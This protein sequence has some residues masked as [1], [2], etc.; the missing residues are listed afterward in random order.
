M[1][2]V[3]GTKLWINLNL[4]KHTDWEKQ[5]VETASASLQTPQ[6]TVALQRMPD[7]VRDNHDAST[8]WE[9]TEERVINKR[10]KLMQ[11]SDVGTLRLNPPPPTSMLLDMLQDELKATTSTAIKSSKLRGIIKCTHLFSDTVLRARKRAKVD[12]SQSERQ[13]LVNDR[14]EAQVEE[15][16][17][18]TVIACTTAT[19]NR[20]NGG[21]N[22]WSKMF[23]ITKKTL[24]LADEIQ[25]LSLLEWAGVSCNA[26]TCHTADA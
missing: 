6:R 21:S 13:E 10:T 23:G 4:D 18:V 1:K 25:A 19:A 15:L 8:E 20:W 7:I 16:R 17:N 24:C 14:R 5:N 9:A 3:A 26:F 11:N 12:K 2:F 22:P